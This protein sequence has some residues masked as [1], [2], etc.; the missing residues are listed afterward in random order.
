[1][2][3]WDHG[4]H[5]TYYERMT[6]AMM[7]LSPDEDIK[8]QI[9]TE[10]S[11]GEIDKSILYAVNV[12]EN[13]KKVSP[14]NDYRV[15]HWQG[16]ANILLG[17]WDQGFSNFRNALSTLQK[18]TKDD[19]QKLLHKVLSYGVHIS[20]AGIAVEKGMLQRAI[21]YLSIA[22]RTQQYIHRNRLKEG[23]ASMLSPVSV[24]R[25]ALIKMYLVQISSERKER[26]VLLKAAQADLEISLDRVNSHPTCILVRGYLASAYRQNGKAKRAL[27]ELD[28]ALYMID[29]YFNKILQSFHG[30]NQT[31]EDQESLN[32]IE[33]TQKRKFLPLVQT[34]WL[35]RAASFIALGNFAD[36]CEDLDAFDSSL[37]KL[38][39]SQKDDTKDHR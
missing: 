10:K 14:A 6:R 8:S 34:L 29:E 9:A 11:P 25:R 23:E 21:R 17:Q 12:L 33:E 13:A 18:S 4:K 16:F 19:K 3:C 37:F 35:E 22:E 39:E 20:C 15:F 27:T 32:M 7:I 31:P 24:W 38:D 36:A 28:C 1:M 5:C 2:N 26:R 30:I